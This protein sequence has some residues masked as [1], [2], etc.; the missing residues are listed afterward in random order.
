MHLVSQSI[1]LGSTGDENRMAMG[2]M[3]NNKGL[4]GRVLYKIVTPL[5]SS[6]RT[7]P[8]GVKGNEGS[9]KTHCNQGRK[10]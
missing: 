4:T 3:E 10:E 7:I 2:L 8:K 1:T 5:S 9:S 6:P